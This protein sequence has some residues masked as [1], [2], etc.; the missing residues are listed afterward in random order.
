MSSTSPMSRATIVDYLK[1]LS[2]PVWKPVTASLTA[3]P[4]A[5]RLGGTPLIG[6]GYPFPRCRKC[7][8][9]LTLFLQL[10][11]RDL[12]AGEEELR[13]AGFEKA[14]PDSILQ[15]FCCI[16]SE[17]K[18]FLDTFDDPECGALEIR[19]VP[20]GTPP[21]ACP[22]KALSTAFPARTIIGWE[23]RQ[24]DYPSFCELSIAC[25]FADFEESEYERV[26]GAMHGREDKL[27]GCPSFFED[28]DEFEC[29]RCGKDM[30]YLFQ[31][32]SQD[33]LPFEFGHDGCG[34]VFLCPEDFTPAF[35]WQSS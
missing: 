27:L 3:A 35:S 12:P 15:L 5:P 16:D 34:Y 7:S 24:F 22:S 10:P 29:A 25:E 8:G 32:K 6:E 11:L 20:A 33:N 4:G 13:D 19:T 9:L 30:I 1:D 21:L 18:C 26:C 23:R 2:R 31:L 14:L 28:A 17:K